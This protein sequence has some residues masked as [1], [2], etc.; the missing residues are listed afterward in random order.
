MGAERFARR[1]VPHD[2]LLLPPR[3]QIMGDKVAITIGPRKEVVT[4]V[5]C[6]FCANYLDGA[7]TLTPSRYI[8]PLRPRGLSVPSEHLDQSSPS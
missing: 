3:A 7:R 4:P 2:V 1:P 5:F 6:A 8:T